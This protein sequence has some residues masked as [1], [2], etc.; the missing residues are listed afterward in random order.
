MPHLPPLTPNSRHAPNREIA[1]REIVPH[2][3]ERG[4]GGGRWLQSQE[5][6][7]MEKRINALE[8]SHQLFLEELVRMQ[9]VSKPLALR[10]H[11]DEWKEQRDIMERSLRDSYDANSSLAHRLEQRITENERRGADDVKK[12]SHSFGEFQAV[13]D[14]HQIEER[15]RMRKMILRIE[16]ELDH[17]AK[18]QMHLETVVGR[19]G[20]R[21]EGGVDKME[22]LLE[23]HQETNAV[24]S[25]LRK[26]VQNLETGHLSLVR[27][28][29]CILTSWSHK[30]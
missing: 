11:Q 14:R 2:R 17:L 1:S 24:L 21:V 4:G 19:Q 26:A 15:E 13:I 7:N 30:V 16:E 27:M 25:R 22:E 9:S 23:Q 18:Q 12:L 3:E 5:L 29:T 20:T 6:G 10:Q 28:G 8:K